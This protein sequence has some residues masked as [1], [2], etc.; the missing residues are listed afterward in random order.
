MLKLMNPVNQ[1]FNLWLQASFCRRKERLSQRRQVPGCPG[2]KEWSGCWHCVSA[3]VDQHLR[4]TQEKP[5]QGLRSGWERWTLSKDSRC[6]CW[7]QWMLRKEIKWNKGLKSERR[8]LLRY[9]EAPND[10]EEGNLWF[11]G[12][13]HRERGGGNMPARRTMYAE[14]LQ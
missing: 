2:Q 12:A 6:Q 11:W 4:S 10:V 13:G 5:L 1:V 14:P 7:W 9:G 3:A 8:C